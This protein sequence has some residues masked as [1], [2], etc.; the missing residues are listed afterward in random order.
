MA[1]VVRGDASE[2]RLQRGRRDERGHH[3]HEQHRAEHRLVQDPGA[4]ADIGED[5]AHLAPRHHA[6]ADDEPPE[7]GPRAR[8]S[9]PPACRRSPARSAP[10]RRPGWPAAPSRAGLSRPRLTEAPTLTKKM[11]V[12]IEATGVTS[13]SMV[14]NWLV[15]E[16]MRPA[17][18][19]PM[20]SA[21]P[22]QRRQWR[23]GRA[24]R[25]WRRRA[26]RSGPACGRRGRR[27]GGRRT[28]PPARR[29]RRKPT[30][31]AKHAEDSETRHRGAGRDA[32]HH[33]EDHQAEHIVDDGGADDDPGLRRVHLPEIGQHPGRD[34]RPRWR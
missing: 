29:P 25:R 12:K 24:R 16:R 30:A 20:M 28:A 22:D 8:P 32:G 1:P 10:P 26:G 11:G 23:P 27:A 14:S 9:R 19:A 7:L 31:T 34:A 2:E 13:C 6:D 17:A 3:H 4:A 33:A 18:K 21:E 5:E 15:P